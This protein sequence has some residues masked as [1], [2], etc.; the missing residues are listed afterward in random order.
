M[1]DTLISNLLGNAIK[2]N[3]LSRN[4]PLLISIETTPN[5]TIRVKNNLNLKKD[6]EQGEGIGLANLT[7]RYNLLFQKGILITQ[8]DVFCVEIPLM[9]QMNQIKI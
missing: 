2:H 4:F 7:D 3:V 1:A 6:P 5:D 9:K 8:T